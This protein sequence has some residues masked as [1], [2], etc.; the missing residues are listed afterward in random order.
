MDNEKAR[1]SA[2]LF[3]LLDVVRSVTLYYWQPLNY[4][5]FERYL[6]GTAYLP[7][8]LYKLGYLF[9]LKMV[10]N[11]QLMFY[12]NTSPHEAYTR[13][14]KNRA[15]KEIFENLE[16]LQI[17]Y[18]KMSRLATRSEW[19]IINGNRSIEEIHREVKSILAL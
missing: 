13:I 7:E 8:A 1:I 9:F 19:I 10:P 2:S 14:E 15:Q 6:M 11:S 3:Y 16:R 4:V 18:R 12:I 17:V 5:V